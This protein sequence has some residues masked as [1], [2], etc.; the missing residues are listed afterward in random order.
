MSPTDEMVEE[1]LQNGEMEQSGLGAALVANS[2]SNQMPIRAQEKETSNIPN[3]E[4][5]ARFR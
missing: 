4:L 5:V 2:Q 1:P 3:Q